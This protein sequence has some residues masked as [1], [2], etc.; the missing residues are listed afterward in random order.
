MQFNVDLLLKGE[1]HATTQTIDSAAGTD[2]RAWTD[3]DVSTVI[4]DMLAAL[5][6]HK[7]PAQSPRPVFLRGISWIVDRDRSGGVLIALE[8][9]TGAAVAGPFD[10]EAAELD[11]MIA[12]VMGRAAAPLTSGVH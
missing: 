9:P 1:E 2:P 12:R 6:R 8:I 5:D 10:I 4:K 11:A 3:A 7:H